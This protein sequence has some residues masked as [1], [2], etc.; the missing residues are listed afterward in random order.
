MG[1]EQL[2]NIL[3]VSYNH[4]AILTRLHFSSKLWKNQIKRHAIQAR[5]FSLMLKIESTTA[6]VSRIKRNHDYLQNKLE[7]RIIKMS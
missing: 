4:D 6:K 5:S 2:G 1:M 3:L 7:F